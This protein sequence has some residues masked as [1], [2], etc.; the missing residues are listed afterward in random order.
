M[1]ENH[2]SG[3]IG[4][5]P[6]DPIHHVA[7]SVKRD[8]R[9]RQLPL[10]AL[11]LGL[12]VEP[13]V[14][15]D[16]TARFDGAADPVGHLGRLQFKDLKAGPVDLTPCLQGVAAVHEQCRPVGRNRAE[17]HRPGEAGQPG[18]PVVAFRHPFTAMG[19][20]TGN[21]EGAHAL[22]G[23]AVPQRIQPGRTVVPV[24]DRRESG[25]SVLRPAQGRTTVG[26]PCPGV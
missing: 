22:P 26:T 8:S 2:R 25:H 18:Q 4:A 6:P 7:G 11:D 15:P 3:R 21:N 1:V 12:R 17:P 23:H 13:G 10:Q 14:E 19:I 5:I 20:R 24:R 16:L 9:F